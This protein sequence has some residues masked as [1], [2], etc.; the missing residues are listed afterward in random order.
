MSYIVDANPDREEGIFVGP[1]ARCGLLSCPRKELLD[2]INDGRHR[3]RIGDNEI[4]VDYS[5]AVSV[6]VGQYLRFV[7]YDCVDVNPVGST[8]ADCNAL[9]LKQYYYSSRQC[10]CGSN[11]LGM[12]GSQVDCLW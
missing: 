12:Q 11:A 5:S 4:D 2:L 9:E 1:R 10:R 7:V 3:W 6:V 8:I